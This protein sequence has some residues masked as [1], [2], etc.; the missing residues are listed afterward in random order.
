[1]RMAILG[2]HHPKALNHFVSDYRALYDDRKVSLGFEIPT[3]YR[4]SDFGVEM[5]YYGRRAR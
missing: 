4:P 1:M 5:E 2:P 3:W